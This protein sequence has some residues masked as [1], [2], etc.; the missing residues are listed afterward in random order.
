MQVVVVPEVVLA[1]EVV[2]VEVVAVAVAVAVMARI[3][4]GMPLL[5][6]TLGAFVCRRRLI[7]QP[8]CLH[9]PENADLKFFFIFQILFQKTQI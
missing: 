4:S 2:A 5:L 1:V 3:S 9:S 6:A 8:K 7:H